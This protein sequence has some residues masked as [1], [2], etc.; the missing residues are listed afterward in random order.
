MKLRFFYVESNSVQQA[1]Q[2]RVLGAWKR[3]KPWDQ[4]RGRQVL[5]LITVVCDDSLH[6]VHIYLL[7]L[8]FDDGW[9]TEESRRDSVRFITAEERWGGGTRK[10]R[11]ALA[12]G[13]PLPVSLQMGIS[14][15]ELLAY[16][17]PVKV[18]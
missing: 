15:K 10:Q 6:P 1:N 16:Y 3:R 14:V 17:D 2:R 11:A 5:N 12:I 18:G 13:G 8:L 4:S 9:I 7:K